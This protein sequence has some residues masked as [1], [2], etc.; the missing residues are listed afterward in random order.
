M[1]NEAKTLHTR[2]Y[3]L[4]FLKFTTIFAM[5]KLCQKQLLIFDDDRFDDDVITN[6]IYHLLFQNTFLF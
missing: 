6:A 2:S 4:K 5:I 3:Y 1:S